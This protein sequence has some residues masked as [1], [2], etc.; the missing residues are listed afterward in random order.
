MSATSVAV[1]G[2]TG[3]IGTQTLEVVAACPGDYE[4]VALGAASSIDLLVEQAERFRPKVVALADQNRAPEL[5]ERV[6]AGTEVLAGPQALAEAAVIAEVA[7]NGVVGFAGLSVTLATLLAGRRLGLA[8]KESLISAGPVV[9]RAR[10]TPG[11]EIL[12]VDSEHCAIHQCLRAN[13]NHERVASIVLTASGGPFRGRSAAEL[14]TITVE[15][16]LDHP[17]WSMG[18]KITVDSSTLMNKGLEVIEARELFGVSY[19][20]IDVVV[21]PQ[22]IVH[23]MVTFS[24][25]ATMAQ[26]SLPDMRL[27]M[28]Y[29]LAYPDRLDVP[30]GAIDW[31]D[32]SRLDFEAPDRE[33]F[34]CLDLAF[35]AGRLGETAP[36]WLNAANEVAVQAFLDG[37]L[38]W[39]GIGETLK[40]ML[41]VWPG[42]LADGVEAVLLA[43]EQSRAATQAL[44]KREA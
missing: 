7:I 4:V 31:T 13:D 2:S 20:Q 18:P 16:A 21:H 36:A 11:A 29:A 10:A 9:Q 22:S 24:D 23:S 6:P 35:T 17:T 12:P 39:V 30:F 28:G 19:D 25:G 42:D 32:L 37:A 1:L 27:C 26:L 34:P 40:K 3:S 38:S 8:N 33:A 43:D 41:E 44:I 15:E 5:A 14:A